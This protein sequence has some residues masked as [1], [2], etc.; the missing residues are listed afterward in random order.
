MSSPQTTKADEFAPVVAA[1][2]SHERFLLTT[3]ENPDGDALG[4]LLAMKLAL[5]QLGKDVTAFLY[6]EAPLPAEYAF[7]ELDSVPRGLPQDAGERVLLAVDCAN[8]DR[9]GPDA[10]VLQSARLVIKIDHHHDNTRF[11]DANL[12]DPHASSTGELLRDLFTEL[13]VE[14]TPAIAEALYI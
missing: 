8:E 7:M 9:L 12:G 4:S 1:I 14:L 5:E 11:G 13:G 10:E 6:G 2:R 3:H